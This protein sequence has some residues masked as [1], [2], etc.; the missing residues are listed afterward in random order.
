MMAYTGD[1]YSELQRDIA[2]LGVGQAN[3]LAQMNECCCNIQ[4]A[5]DGVNY[6]TAMQTAQINANTTEQTQRILDAITGNRMADMQNRINTLETAQMLNPIEQRLSMVPTYPNGF[7]Y[8]AG[9]NPFCN[10]GN[11]GNCCNNI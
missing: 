6:N 9:S 3:Q 4:R 2:A 8:N 5:I 11:Y 7:T 1:K 10:C